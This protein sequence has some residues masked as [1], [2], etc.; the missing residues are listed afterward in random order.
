MFLD[1]LLFVSSSIFLFN[2]IFILFTCSNAVFYLYLLPALN[3]SIWS[4]MFSFICLIFINFSFCILA[5]FPNTIYFS[6]F[7]YDICSLIVS[8]FFT[9][10]LLMHLLIIVLSSLLI[11][12]MLLL[13]RVL[14]DL[15]DDVSCYRNELVYFIICYFK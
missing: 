1:F 4:C 10:C 12:S 5:N 13:I 3:R 6:C 9:D 7:S 11:C 8:D 2:S 14:V 15:L